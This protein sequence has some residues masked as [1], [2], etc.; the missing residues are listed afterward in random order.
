MILY[1]AR[2]IACEDGLKVYFDKWICK[3]ETQCFYFCASELE[4][5][6]SIEFLKKNKKLKKIAKMNSRFAFDLQEKAL[7]QLRFIKTRQLKHIEREQD[8]IKAFLLC[9]DFK[10]LNYG[11][12]SIP[13]TSYLVSKHISF[14]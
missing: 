8:F 5:M 11:G 4:S 13:H 6:Q 9:D 1:K 7:K 3:H 14:D 2:L 12:L 10:S